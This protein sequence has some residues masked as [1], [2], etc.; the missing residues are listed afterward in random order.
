M[1]SNVGV[2]SVIVSAAQRRNTFV[3]TS[4]S[5]VQV[6]IQLQQ[7]LIIYNSNNVSRS[8]PLLAFLTMQL[9]PNS[10]MIGSAPSYQMLSHYSVPESQT[11]T[12]PLL[13]TIP[14]NYCLSP[15]IELAV[16][17]HPHP[18]FLDTTSKGFNITR[19]ITTVVATTPCRLQAVVRGV[20]HSLA[21]HI[22]N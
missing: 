5:S 15:V 10:S 21:P 2:V 13:P 12:L 6:L 14:V 18:S 19:G 20:C 16:Q 11:F 9:L 1:C 8:Q 3:L 17:R 4:P 22:V 7:C